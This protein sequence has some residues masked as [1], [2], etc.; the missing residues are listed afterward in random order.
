MSLKYLCR[1]SI[2]AAV[3]SLLIVGVAVAA[4]PQKGKT[5][6]GQTK[7]KAAQSISF[8]VSKN[9]KSVT[10]L[11]A[12]IIQKCTGPVGGFGGIKNKEPKKI[13]ISSKGTFKVVVKFVAVVGKKSFGKETVTGTF[14]KGGKEKGKITSKPHIEKHCHGTTVKYSTVAGTVVVPPPI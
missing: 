3:V 10:N 5:Y 11:N 6:F 1:G 9:G 12:P 13:K 7:Q 14:L 4:K 8:T 2:A